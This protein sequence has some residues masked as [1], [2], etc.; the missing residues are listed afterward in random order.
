MQKLKTRIGTC[1]FVSLDA[2]ERYYADYGYGAAE[3]AEKLAAGEIAVGRPEAEAGQIVGVIS[4][5]GRYYIERV[6]S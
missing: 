5:E 4:G 1:H 3:V 6:G 2:A